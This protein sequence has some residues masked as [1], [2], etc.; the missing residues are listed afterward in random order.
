M[1][2]IIQNIFFDHSE[3]QVAIKR[4]RYITPIALKLIFRSKEKSQLKYLNET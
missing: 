1:I 3:T 2:E 4:K